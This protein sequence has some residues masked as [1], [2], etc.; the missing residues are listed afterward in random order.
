VEPTPQ[1]AGAFSTQLQAVSCTSPAAC[2]AVGEYNPS[3]S[4]PSQR[5]L[6]ERWDGTGWSIQRTPRAPGQSN[7]L[8]AVSCSSSRACVAVGQT[9]FNGGQPLVERKAGSSWSIERMPPPKVDGILLQAVS[10][11][12]SAICTAVGNTRA[13]GVI[14]EQSAD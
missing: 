13:E 8:V 1:V 12:S 7:G 14:A 6:A 3:S 10:C 2:I 11:T 4:R 5:T 9:A